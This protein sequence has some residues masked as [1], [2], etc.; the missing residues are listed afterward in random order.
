MRGGKQGARLLLLGDLMRAA[1]DRLSERTPAAS[2]QYPLARRQAALLAERTRETFPPD[3]TL[4][5]QKAVAAGVGLVVGLGPDMRW[6]L[7][8][9]GDANDD[10]VVFALFLEEA[11]DPALEFVSAPTATSLQRVLPESQQQRSRYLG[12]GVEL[13]D[14]F[15][16]HL[17]WPLPLGHPAQRREALRDLAPFLMPRPAVDRGRSSG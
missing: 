7:M 16:R 14:A 13:E 15:G 11:E 8:P 6:V 4:D 5:E 10:R 2:V 1:V 12:R 9:P 3:R 17:P